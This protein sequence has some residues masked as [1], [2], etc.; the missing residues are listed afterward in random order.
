[1]HPTFPILFGFL[2]VFGGAATAQAADVPKAIRA[3]VACHS[4]EAGAKAKIGP[5]LFGVF[6]KPAAAN[7]DYSQYGESLKEAAAKGL[8]WTAE[9]LNAYIDDPI[10]FLKAK[11]GEAKVRTNMIV[12]VRAEKDRDA[13]VEYLQGLK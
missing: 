12:R 9:N 8:V 7:P 10:G 1:M 5:N 3:C 6:G 2:A 4:F 11:T 13:I